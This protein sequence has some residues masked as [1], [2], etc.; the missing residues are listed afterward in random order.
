MFQVSC[1]PK[2]SPKYITIFVYVFTYL[3]IFLY[4]HFSNLFQLPV[5]G[6]QC[7]NKVEGVALIGA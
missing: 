5:N 4:L 1:G 7:Q 6:T 3:Y 2:Q